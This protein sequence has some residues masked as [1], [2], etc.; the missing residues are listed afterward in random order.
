LARKSVR[1]FIQEWTKKLQSLE[2]EMK[3]S[4]ARLRDAVTEA[5]TSANKAAGH[6]QSINDS[7][8]VLNKALEDVDKL[9][10]FVA[11]LHAQVGRELVGEAPSP[12]VAEA[13][14]AQPP[15]EPSAADEDAEVAARLK[16]K[17]NSAEGEG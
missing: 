6:A 1:E 12:S 3:D 5:E 2:T 13:A 16:G 4:M 14:V 17:I 8:K 10:T 9:R 11:S 7:Q 15:P